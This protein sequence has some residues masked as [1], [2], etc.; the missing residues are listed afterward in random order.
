MRDIGIGGGAGGCGGGFE[1]GVGGDC[2]G[3]VGAVRVG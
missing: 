3:D 1:G 2:E